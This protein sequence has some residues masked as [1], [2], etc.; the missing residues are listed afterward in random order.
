MDQEQGRITSNLMKQKY[1]VNA[2]SSFHMNQLYILISC[3]IM[4]ISD[5]K[6]SSY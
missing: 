2:V 4:Q 6:T 5:S 3:F 1:G